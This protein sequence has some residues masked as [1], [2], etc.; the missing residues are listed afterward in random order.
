MSCDIDLPDIV[1]WV[2]NSFNQ[3]NAVDTAGVSGRDRDT[4]QETTIMARQ[5]SVRQNHQIKEVFLL[6]DGNNSG[7]VTV[8]E[9]RS[10]LLPFVP[11]L[12][13]C[14][15]SEDVALLDAD[16]NAHVDFN[17]F[18]V[19]VTSLPTES[20]QDTL[21]FVWTMLIIAAAKDSEIALRA[22]RKYDKDGDGAITAEELR[23]FMAPAFKAF[24]EV[25]SICQLQEAIKDVDAD[26]NRTVDFDEFKNMLAILEQRI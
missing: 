17:E 24:G 19:M 25:P 7:G 6:F 4:Q 20:S 22:F 9:L 16:K 12:S 1:V 26:G 8:E 5:F 21:L 10:F 11:D 13:D 15:L 18:L 2:D 3:L 14:K 23:G